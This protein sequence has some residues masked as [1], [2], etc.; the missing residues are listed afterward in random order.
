MSPNHIVKNI[1]GISAPISAWLSIFS[2][3]ITIGVFFVS[4]IR[5]DAVGKN[6]LDQIDTGDIRIMKYQIEQLNANICE[7]NSNMKV[8]NAAFMRHIEK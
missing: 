7:M 3:I 8:L 4:A 2:M 1:S 6:K 5:A